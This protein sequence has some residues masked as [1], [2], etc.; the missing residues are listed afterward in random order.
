METDGG[1]GLLLRILPF[2]MFAAA[3]GTGVV[4]LGFE[5]EA[6]VFIDEDEL[7]VGLVI[8][9]ATGDVSLLLVVLLLL[10][11]EENEEDDDDDKVVLPVSVLSFSLR[12]SLKSSLNGL[13]RPST[14]R[15]RFTE[16]FYLAIKSID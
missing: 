4:G 14:W 12:Y 7:G 9:V 13:L 8:V 10:W 6:L 15:R 5:W 2:A 16:C 3:F 1:V 11:E